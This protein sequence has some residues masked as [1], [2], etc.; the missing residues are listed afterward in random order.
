MYFE[1]LLSCSSLNVGFKELKGLQT[2][3][4]EFLLK[5]YQSVNRAA[6]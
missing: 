3:S 4:T 2:L 6:L 5:E 1:D